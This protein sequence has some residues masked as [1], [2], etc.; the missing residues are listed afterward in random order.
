LSL[1]LPFCEFGPRE[2]PTSAS[3]TFAT[4]RLS[5]QVQGYH[6]VIPN[7][8]RPTLARVVEV[9]LGG[10]GMPRARAQNLAYTTGTACR[11]LDV[12]L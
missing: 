9:P 7:E 12:V 8:M 3:R 11:K 5:P 6:C 4:Q 2:A 10:E 1:Q